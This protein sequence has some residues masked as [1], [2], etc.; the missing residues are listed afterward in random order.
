MGG[1]S[2]CQKTL[3]ILLSSRTSPQTGAPQGGLSWP[4][5]PIHLLAISKIVVKTMDYQQKMLENPGDFHVGLRPPRND[6]L[7]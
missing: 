3:K 1:L 6:T 5:G 7:F 4:L 2:A